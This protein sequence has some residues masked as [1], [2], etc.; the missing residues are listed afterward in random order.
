MEKLAENYN[1]MRYAFKI[2]LLQLRLGCLRDIY[3]YINN[4]CYV[5]LYFLYT[6]QGNIS[7]TPKDTVDEKKW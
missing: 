7:C 3:I 4:L 2:H 1:K 6:V 5:A